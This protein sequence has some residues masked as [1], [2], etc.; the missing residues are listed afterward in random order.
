MHMLAGEKYALNPAPARWDLPMHLIDTV[1][2]AAIVP[3]AGDEEATVESLLRVALGEGLS[4][5]QIT[6]MPHPVL[7]DEQ[8]Y[9]SALRPLVARCA[10]SWMKAH[11][12]FSPQHAA[13]E[14]A[15][16][17]APAADEAAVCAA[18]AWAQREYREFS[19]AMAAGARALELRSTRVDDCYVGTR[20]RFFDVFAKGAAVRV[21]S[22]TGRVGN[23]C[24]VNPTISI[25]SRCSLSSWRHVGEGVFKSD[26]SMCTIV[27][28]K[29]V[30]IE[31]GTVGGFLLHSL[32]SRY[33]VGA[34][35]KGDNSSVDSENADVALHR[36]AICAA[37]QPDPWG[38]TA[39]FGRDRTFCGTLGYE[40]VVADSAAAAPTLAAAPP[41]N[42]AG[43]LLEYLERGNGASPA[44]LETIGGLPPKAL[45]VVNVAQ[46]RFE[47][48]LLPSAAATGRRCRCRRCPPPPSP[49][50]PPPLL[51]LLF[52]TIVARVD[53]RTGMDVL[54]PPTRAA[55]DQPRL[56]WSAAR[57]RRSAVDGAAT[58]SAA[59][60]DPVHWQRHPCA[61]RRVCPARRA[62]WRDGAGVPLRRAAAS[63]PEGGGVPAQ[64]G[65]AVREWAGGA[66]SNIQDV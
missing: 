2:Q 24:K 62:H 28:D 51:L 65:N 41:V 39:R 16:C 31:P 58:V 35:T 46:V 57:C 61:S 12:T 8:F 40:L 38:T 42:M 32:D 33:A 22:L 48:L 56:L 15:V 6:L 30:L 9:A 47:L 37:D 64:G 63:Q 3:A 59:A 52:L 17:A 11:H 43:A 50:P 13:D 60:R 4:M 19:S 25:Y 27:L 14:A 20:G 55:Q 66:A 10:A 7:L 34:A 49:P 29:P 18:P 44:V 1:L 54:L 45:Q 23:R 21:T 53:A 5:R 36:G 26:Q